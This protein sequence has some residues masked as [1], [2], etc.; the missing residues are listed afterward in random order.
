M[1]EITPDISKMNY[2]SYLYN[3]KPMED[4]QTENYRIIYDVPEDI[5]GQYDIENND[6]DRYYLSENAENKVVKNVEIQNIPEIETSNDP[7]IEN[8]Q[9]GGKITFNNILLLVVVILLVILLVNWFFTQCMCGDD[10][11]YFNFFKDSSSSSN[12]S[13]IIISF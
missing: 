7:I 10:E 4:S 3:V 1:N 5:L 12:P 8:F 11:D 13:P 6:N 9:I 2:E